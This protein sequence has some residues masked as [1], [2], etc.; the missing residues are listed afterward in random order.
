MEKTIIILLTCLTLV[1]LSGCFEKQ[2][3]VIKKIERIPAEDISEETIPAVVMLPQKTEAEKPERHE[4][5]VPEI[6]VATE[7]SVPKS[8]EKDEKVESDTRLTEYFSVQKKTEDTKTLSKKKDTRDGKTESEIKTYKSPIVIMAGECLIYRIKW[9]SVN[10]GKLLL[11]CK[12]EK[13]NNQDVYHIMGIT[14]PEG[15]WTKVGNGY[16]RFD[17]YIDSKNNLPFYY[18]NYSASSSAYQITKSVIDQ[19]TKALTYEIKKYKEGKQYGYKTGKVNFEGIVFDGL[20]A[21]YAMRGIAGE[22]M[23]PSKMPVG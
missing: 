9:N 15:I 21:I 8:E 14:V 17:S 22:S 7:K 6:K 3:T 23:A 16:N 13:M 2:E 12:K 1:F 19:K 5:P 18:Y 20:S 10:V 11:A 4:S